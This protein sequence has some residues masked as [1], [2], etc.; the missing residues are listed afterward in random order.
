VAE[1][2]AEHGGKPFTA[3]FKG[4]KEFGNPELMSNV[5]E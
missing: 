5:S 2:L 4:T 3:V 1:Y